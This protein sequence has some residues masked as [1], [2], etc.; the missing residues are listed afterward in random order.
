M[1]KYKTIFGIKPN[2][3]RF[4]DFVTFYQVSLVTNIL[5]KNIEPVYF[6]YILEHEPGIYYIYNKKIKNVPEIFSAKHTGY[7]LRA[8]EL[9]AR[10]NNQECKDQLRFVVEWL[11][12]NRNEQNKWD[13]GKESK[14]GI[15]LPLLD[16][17]RKDEHRIEDCTNRINRLIKK[18]SG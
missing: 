2:G 4:I 14:D 12:K 13:L 10:Y 3:G 7:Y 11:R 17:W 18:I 9:L 16:S 8:I 15:S 6:K 5:D 1:E